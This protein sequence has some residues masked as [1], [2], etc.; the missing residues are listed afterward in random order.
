MGA[1]WVKIN[2]FDV[3]PARDCNYEF[4]LGRTFGIEAEWRAS[5]SVK[6]LD[7]GAWSSVPGLIRDYGT[8]VYI[9]YTLPSNL[10]NLALE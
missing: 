9:S 10:I 1:H 4:T 2:F 7:L 8:S 6:H 5:T 3:G